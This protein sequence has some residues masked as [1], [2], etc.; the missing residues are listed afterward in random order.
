MAV[1][2]VTEPVKVAL[3]AK[4]RHLNGSAAN[5][6]GDDADVSVFAWCDG[7][8]VFIELPGVDRVCWSCD[9]IALLDG[10]RATGFRGRT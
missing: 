2:P 7:E 8:T 1:E 6:S 3:S 4:R 10:I 5:G 9:L